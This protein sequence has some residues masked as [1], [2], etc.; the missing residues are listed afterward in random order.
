MSS[1]SFRENCTAVLAALSFLLLPYYITTTSKEFL[2]WI[3]I[4]CFT[5]WCLK[6]VV[7]IGDAKSQERSRWKPS[8][9][10]DL[11]RG[12]PP[13]KANEIRILVLYPSKDRTAPLQ[14][15]FEIYDLDNGSDT[16]GKADQNGYEAMFN[17][18]FPSHPMEFMV[19]GF[20][21]VLIPFHLQRAL[22]WLRHTHEE[23]RLWI[24]AICVKMPERITHTQLFPQI[25]KRATK[26]IAWT[27]E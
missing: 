27:G 6:L 16:S 3:A 18:K 21:V 26:A 25:Y 11:L 22:L 14:G 1:N 24:D 15:R 23:R 7:N 17:T 2:L 10:L 8:G 9:V 12:Y 4:S 13:L 5:N 20:K 19:I